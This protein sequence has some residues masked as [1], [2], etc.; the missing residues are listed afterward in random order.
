MKSVTVREA[1]RDDLPA[2][3]E[4]YNYYIKNT[5]ITFDLNPYSVQ[6]REEWFQHYNHNPR[7]RLLV[8]EKNGELVGYSSSSPFRP[9]DAYLTSIETTVYLTPDQKTKGIGALL[10]RSLFEAI[11][12]A[13]IHKAYGLIT[14]PNDASFALHKKFGFVRVGKFTEVGRKFGQYHDVELW[15]KTLP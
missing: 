13:D 8:A 10:Y 7:H 2:L 11:E 6:D 9:K 4:L 12:G 14:A 15:E 3:T 5:A 1:I